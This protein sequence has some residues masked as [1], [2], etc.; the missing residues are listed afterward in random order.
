ML[1]PA[2]GLPRPLPAGELPLL[3]VC[4][5]APMPDCGWSICALALFTAFAYAA[6][7]ALLFS[8]CAITVMRGFLWL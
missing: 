2:D 5:P 7:P 6:A 4:L 1:T 3:R 8:S